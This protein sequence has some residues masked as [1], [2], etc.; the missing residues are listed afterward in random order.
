MRT[1]I[2]MFNV[3]M[4]LLLL[5]AL[6]RMNARMQPEPSTP[7]K[8]VGKESVHLTKICIEGTWDECIELPE[9]GTFQV[10]ILGPNGITNE[11]V[12]FIKQ[13]R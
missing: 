7:V 2:I 12:L 11:K 1:A 4:L 9:G 6:F 13:Q 3:C 10:G 8:G 5:M